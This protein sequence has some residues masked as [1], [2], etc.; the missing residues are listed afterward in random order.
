MQ[1]ILKSSI[2]TQ[3]IVNSF[4]SFFLFMI[5]FTIYAILTFNIQLII[6]LIILIA[7]QKIIGKRNNIVIKLLKT[8]VRPHQYFRK[9]ER[10]F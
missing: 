10:I 6:F 8:Y 4:F 5:I 1:T 7:L 3:F 2:W 9:F